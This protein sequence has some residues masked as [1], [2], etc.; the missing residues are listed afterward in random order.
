MG[1][2]FHSVT[3]LICALKDAP[4]IACNNQIAAIQALH[5]AI[6]RWSK[7]TLP[8]AKVPQV[9]THPPMHTQQRTILCPMHRPTKDQAQDLFPRVVIQKRNTSLS[10]T[11]V[12]STKN[13]YEPVAQHTRSRVPHTVYQPSPRVRKSIY[14]GPIARHT[15]SQTAV[16]ANVITPAQSD[17]QQYLY[18]FLQSLAMPVL[19]ESSGQSLQYRQKHNHP[20]FAHIWN[21]SCSNELG[22]LLQGIIK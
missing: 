15:I 9:N 5:Q 16:T 12:P 6:Q 8:V 20:K 21:T 7:P 17:K 22:R 18:Q 4:T 3:T 2:I 11:K 1:R 13:N 14:I 19:D 10:T